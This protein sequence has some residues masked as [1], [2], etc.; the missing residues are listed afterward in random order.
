MNSPSHNVPGEAP[1]PMGRRR[2]LVAV[3]VGVAVVGLLLAAGW[4]G[5][6]RTHPRGVEFLP[7]AL[8]EYWPENTGGVLTL[9][10]RQ[11]LDSPVG[12]QYLR[13]TFRQII[14]RGETTHP[15]MALLGI[16]P[17]QDLDQV[18]VI[19]CA[20]DLGRPLWLLSGRIHAERF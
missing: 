18:Q 10:L 8:A 11:L 17:G 7:G 20:H 3:V 4:Y 14:R 12:R 15:W 5:W 6:L 19:Y 9:H 16:D 2:R 13:E 1:P